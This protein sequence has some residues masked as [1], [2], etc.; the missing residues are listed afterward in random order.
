[1]PLG[2]FGHGDL[3]CPT[4]PWTDGGKPGPRISGKRLRIFSLSRVLPY[5]DDIEEELPFYSKSLK[6][7]LTFL[8][9]EGSFSEDPSFEGILFREGVPPG[10]SEIFSSGE[11]VFPGIP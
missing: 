3:T 8:E 2:F 5:R 7:W 10:K 9:E 4:R 6:N 1:M 11:I